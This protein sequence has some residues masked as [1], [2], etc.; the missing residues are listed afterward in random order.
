MLGIAKVSRYQTKVYSLE[1]PLL[2][3]TQ[4]N[5]LCN[6]FYV[7]NV[8]FKNTGKLRNSIGPLHITD[9]G[10]Y[11]LRGLYF[12]DLFTILPPLCVY[13]HHTFLRR[14]KLNLT[15]LVA[16]SIFDYSYEESKHI[17]SLNTLHFPGCNIGLRQMP[18]GSCTC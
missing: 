9:L 5:H 18:S 8:G 17:F 14:E 15:G 6:L 3:P 2:S 11:Y 10:S 1:P 13:F 12:I 16:L 7:I 4:G